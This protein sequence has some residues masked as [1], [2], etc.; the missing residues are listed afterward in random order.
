MKHSYVPEM[1]AS[2]KESAAYDDD[3]RGKSAVSEMVLVELADTIRVWEACPTMELTQVFATQLQRLPILDS[4]DP[5]TWQRFW[6]RPY[7]AVN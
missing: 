1:A 2:T 3:K 7:T 4:K 6:S 5:A